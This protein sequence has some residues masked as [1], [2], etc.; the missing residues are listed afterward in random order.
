MKNLSSLLERFK[1]SLGNDSFIKEKII[2]C[3]EDKTK[4]KLSLEEVYL[5]N[6]IL[7]I[8][9][10]PI[11]NNEIRLKEDLIIKDLKTNQKLEI[12]KIFYK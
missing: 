2:L 3:I 10:T 1:K 6:A 9:S 11:K 4:I 12:N 5:K 8:K 7:E